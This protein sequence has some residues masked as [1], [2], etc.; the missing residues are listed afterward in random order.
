MQVENSTAH[1]W[2]IR[3]GL[4]DFLSKAKTCCASLQTLSR[5][6]TDYGYTIDSSQEFTYS[7]VSLTQYSC[8][9]L[10]GYMLL[11]YATQ[12]DLEPKYGTGQN[13]GEQVYF[14]CGLANGFFT[15]THLT[16]HEQQSE[17]M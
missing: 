11:D 9:W 15:C 3:Q 10:A 5:E 14:P 4:A 12:L 2:N 17:K 7:F 13:I 16:M 6:D 8:S 1:S